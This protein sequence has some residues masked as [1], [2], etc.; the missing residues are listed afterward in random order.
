MKSQVKKLDKLKRIL[1]VEVGEGKIR[2]M[3][4]KN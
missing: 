1:E 2:I 4:I 3:F